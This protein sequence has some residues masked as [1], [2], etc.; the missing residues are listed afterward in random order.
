MEELLYELR[1]GVAYVSFNRPQA[2]NAL[3]FAMYERLAEI[4]N[5]ANNDRAIRAILLTGAGDKAFAAGTDISQFRAFDK[6]ADALAYEE[7]IDRVMNAIERCRV[8]TIAAIHGACTGGGAS[9]AAC[10]DL[11]IASRSMKYGFPVA[12][13]LG[14]CLSL[15]SYNR[16]V[17]LVGPALVKDIVFQARLIEADEALAKG[18]VNELCED[19]AALLKRAEELAR[20]VA[21]MAPL[22]LQATKEALLRLR[23]KVAHGEGNDLVLMCYMSQDFREGMEAFLNKRKPSWKGR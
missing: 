11:R 15:A 5:N 19:Q 12:R 6:E 17:Y 4:C 14:N 7:R 8:P 16:L 2:R 13:T 9:I 3:T 21:S 1:D 22:T 18:L 20:L 23:P 10:C